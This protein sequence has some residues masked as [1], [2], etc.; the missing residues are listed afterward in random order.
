MEETVTSR[1]ATSDRKATEIWDMMDTHKAG[2]GGWNGEGF[3]EEVEP[4]LR[5]QD[6]TGKGAGKQGDSSKAVGAA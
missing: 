3:L 6:D 5:P 4:K 1:V 2:L